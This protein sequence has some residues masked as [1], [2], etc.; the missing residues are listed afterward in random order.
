MYQTSEKP[1]VRIAEFS[2]QWEGRTIDG[3]F[4]LR[5]FL[6]SGEN[7]AVFLTT[8]EERPAAIKL[9]HVEPG[10]ADPQLAQWRAAA[11]LSH[12]NLIR[13]YG[14]GRCE[15]DALPLLYI[16]MEYADEDLSQVLPHRSLSAAE[17]REMLPPAL[18][19]LEYLHK[20]G[21]VHAHLKPSN[22]MAADDCLKLSSDGLCRAGAK[23][24][25][26]PGPH[27]PPERLSGVVSP[28]GD[29]WSLGVTL[30]EVLT[31][32]HP[33]GGGD[34]RTAA[35]LPEP[36]SV[37]VRHA[38]ARDARERWTIPQISNY[39]VDPS[40][41]AAVSAEPARR[42]RIAP[43]GVLILLGLVVV[44]VAGVMIRHADTGTP[45]SATQPAS[46]PTGAAS[47]QEP[48]PQPQQAQAEP[49]K[50]EKI[51][52]REEPKP[53]LEAETAKP[54]GD[55]SP[56][57]DVQPDSGAPGQPMPEVTAQARNTIR[58]QVKLSVR[59][60]VDPAGA[61]TDAKIEGSGGSRY[62]SDLAL[63]TVR[64]WKFEPV[65]VNGSETGQRWRVRFEF[66]KSGTKVQRQRLSP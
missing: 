39:L 30:I 27:D 56:G 52:K 15:L 12:P 1:T 34:V 10:K 33:S 24:E 28:A 9:L 51:G 64:N 17:A 48:P 22:I 3:A 58:G 53:E 38:L 42:K 41:V 7:S 16:V 31:G 47:T 43:V 8:Y 54:V 63:K 65:K 49:P 37:I 29:V 57:S 62:F 26:A 36:F 59:V 6:G 5:Q 21:F 50:P 55:P 14:M 44:V 25:S 45:A 18:G 32:R 66:L 20:Q 23:D 60:D 13:I 46:T 4:S 2:A 35:D 11:K 61:V 19:A 40:G